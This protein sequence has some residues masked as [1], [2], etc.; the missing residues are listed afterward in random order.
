MNKNF[1][2]QLD[3]LKDKI[4]IYKKYKKEL[5][6]HLKKFAKGGKGVKKE[7]KE[8]VILE[9]KDDGNHKMFTKKFPESKDKS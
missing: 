6:D 7:T 3:K 1:D 8:E 4:E 9:K 5:E 2:I